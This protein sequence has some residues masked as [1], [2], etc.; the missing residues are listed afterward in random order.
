MKMADW[1]ETSLLPKT[2][3]MIM[4]ISQRVFVGEPLCRSEEWVSGFKIHPLYYSIDRPQ[5]YCMAQVTQK[6]FE[7]APELW[8]HNAFTRPF[9]A[10]RHPAL[11]SVREHKKRAEA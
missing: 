7:G 10:W 11:R 6:A 8:N 1:T 3:S 4:A 2:I 9:A 5:L